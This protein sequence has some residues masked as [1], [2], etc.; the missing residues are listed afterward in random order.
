MTQL[1]HSAT[2][3]IAIFQVIQIVNK[4]LFGLA[5]MAAVALHILGMEAVTMALDTMVASV[6]FGV[7]QATVWVVVYKGFGI[8]IPNIKT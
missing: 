8:K 5:A 2:T 7:L 3:L 6:A 1:T 4:L